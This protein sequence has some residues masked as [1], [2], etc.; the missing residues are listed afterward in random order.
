MNSGDYGNY[1]LACLGMAALLWAYMTLM[2]KKRKYDAKRLKKM[3]KQL[4]DLKID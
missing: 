2:K 3:E 4:K 1:M